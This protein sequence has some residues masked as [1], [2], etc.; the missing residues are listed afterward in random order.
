MNPIIIGREM[1]RFIKMA[2][3]TRANN[4]F[5]AISKNLLPTGSSSEASFE[6]KVP[7]TKPRYAISV[8]SRYWIN[9]T[10]FSIT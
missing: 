7:T 6:I 4:P 5:L 8:V 9:R 2:A 1:C 3:M 10:I